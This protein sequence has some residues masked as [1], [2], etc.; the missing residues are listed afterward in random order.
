MKGAIPKGMEQVNPADMAGTFCHESERPQQEDGIQ[1]EE[2]LFRSEEMFQ[3]WRVWPHGQRQQMP[4]RKERQWHVHVI[5]RVHCMHLE[6]VWCIPATQRLW[7]V[8][9][10]RIVRASFFFFFLNQQF[11]TRGSIAVRGW[12]YKQKQHLQL[13]LPKPIPPPKSP[14]RVVFKGPVYRTGKK[15]GTGLNWTD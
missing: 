2:H 15:T 10:R 6:A 3:L 4:A 14:F 11:I 8:R 12:S 7:S 5:R 1:Q 13:R 9:S